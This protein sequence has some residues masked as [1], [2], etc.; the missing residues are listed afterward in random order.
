VAKA[1]ATPEFRG[2]DSERRRLLLAVHNYCT[3]DPESGQPQANCPSHLILTNQRIMDGML[4]M[5]RRVRQLT[6]EE[7]QRS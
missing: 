2:T 7:G 6:R 4:F 3:C 5:L 1:V